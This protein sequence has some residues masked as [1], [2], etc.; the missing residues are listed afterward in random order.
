MRNWI[1]I[2]IALLFAVD[3]NG[4]TIC[5]AQKADSAAS[6]ATAA[7]RQAKKIV[8]TGTIEPKK[9]LAVCSQVAGQIIRLGADPRSP[10]GLVDYGSVVEVGTLLAELDPRV[11][12]ARVDQAEAAYLR[13]H[14][15]LKLA[16]V[17]VA[18]AAVQAQRAKQKRIGVSDVEV[19]QAAFDQDAAKVAVEAAKA[20]LMQ[21]KAALDEARID[22]DHTTITSPVKGVIIDRRVN[23]GQT[24]SPDLNA[25]SLFMIADLDKLQV[26]ASVKEADITRIHRGQSVRF[27][28][29]ALPGK[30]FDGKVEQIRLNAQMTQNIVTYTVVVA[31]TGSQEKLLPYLT[32]K[33]EFE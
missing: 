24:I 16:E 32:A 33:L 20:S 13:A 29:D 25:P 1:V 4:A 31:I 28:L 19:E 11:Y 30:T 22:L 27:T 10:S 2:P 8:A 23:V 15:E 3:N 14:A 9:A 26:W 17:N 5:L 7:A 18:R 21:S 6:A 12:K